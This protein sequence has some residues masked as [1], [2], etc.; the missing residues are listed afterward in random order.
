MPLPKSKEK[1]NHD[2]IPRT[3]ER[4]YDNRINHETGEL[5]ELTTP[6]GLAEVEDRLTANLHV[7]RHLHRRKARLQNH[8]NIQ[9]AQ[10]ELEINAIELHLAECLA[11]EQQKEEMLLVES[12]LLL[13]NLDRKSYEVKDIGRIKDYVV[14]RAKVNI[15]WYEN[16]NEADKFNFQ[17][18]HPTLF[19]SP[20]EPKLLMDEVK[21]GLKDGSLEQSGFILTEAVSAKM[22]K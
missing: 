8:A 2:Y 20:E 18:I 10:A 19:K 16:L 1:D 15:T 9:V 14:E 3:V 11:N 4:F 22:F 17:R 12:R 7:L 6:T 21:K 13:A 5:T